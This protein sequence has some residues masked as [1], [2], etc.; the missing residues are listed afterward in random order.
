MILVCI[1]CDAQIDLQ[2]GGRDLHSIYVSTVT[3]EIYRIDSV[4][5]NPTNPIL[6]LSNIPS[7]AGISINSNLDSLSGPETMYYVDYACTYYFWNGANW[8]NTNNTSG[9]SNAVNPGGTSSYIF[10][11]DGIGNKLYRYDGITNSTLLISNLNTNGV[12]MYD[13]ATDNQGNFY[14]FYSNLQ[15]IIVYNQIGI[16][17]DSFSI[18]GL[19]IGGGGFSIL[20]NRMYASTTDELYEGIKSG[21][22]I[23]FTLIKS[24][25][26]YVSDMAT[27]PEAASPLSDINDV[28]LLPFKLYPNPMS[29]VLNVTIFKDDEFNINIYDTSSRL[30]IQRTFKNT[31][32]INTEKLSKGIYLYELRNIKGIYKN[33]IVVKN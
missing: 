7:C 22:N 14:L 11:L 1:K 6:I 20:G 26:F 28:L 32:S 10:N 16:P 25:P 13:V 27:C 33:G 19:T 5:T 23:H 8:T 9:G 24:L 31:T 4:D 29:N 18:S 17:I 30:I 15:M 21:S 3:N 2:C 12:S